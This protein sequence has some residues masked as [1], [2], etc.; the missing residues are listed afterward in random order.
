MTSSTFLSVPQ[1]KMNF[2]MLMTVK[3]ET[4][5]LVIGT[6]Y[7]HSVRIKDLSKR[8]QHYGGNIDKKYIKLYI[9]QLDQE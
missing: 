2:N 1:K 4:N 6:V 5:I 8:L 7:S 3:N 9:L